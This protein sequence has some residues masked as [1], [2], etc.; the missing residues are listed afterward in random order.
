M[1][2]LKIIGQA[3]G[4]GSKTTLKSMNSRKHTEILRIIFEGIL[5]WRLC[6]QRQQEEDEGNEGKKKGR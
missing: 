2:S 3:A 1:E 6:A 5:S 4:K